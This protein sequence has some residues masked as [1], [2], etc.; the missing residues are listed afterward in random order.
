[1]VW[2]V[3][4]LA[5]AYQ[6]LGDMGLLGRVLDEEIRI[7]RDMMGGLDIRLVEVGITA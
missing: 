7:K 5:E 6:V 1:L 2:E 3:E 4:S